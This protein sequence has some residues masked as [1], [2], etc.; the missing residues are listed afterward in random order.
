[1]P[2]S[3]SMT[4]VQKYEPREELYEVSCAST[5]PCF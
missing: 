4:Y 1:M 3:L 5:Y 2:A